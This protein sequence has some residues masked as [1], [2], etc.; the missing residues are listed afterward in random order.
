MWP[1][2]SSRDFHAKAVGQGRSGLTAPQVEID[3][4][5]FSGLRVY[6][7]LSPPARSLVVHPI[8]HAVL[9]TEQNQPVTFP[10]LFV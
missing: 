5:H 6:Q 9:P 8:E 2:A 10:A 7:E 3:N 1:L 4:V